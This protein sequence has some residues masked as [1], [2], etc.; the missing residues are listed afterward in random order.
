MISLG[1]GVI[2]LPLPYIR[3]EISTPAG[4]LFAAGALAF[5]VIGGLIAVLLPPLI[6]LIQVLLRPRSV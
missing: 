4:R 6:H 3:L 2:C 5:I 1:I